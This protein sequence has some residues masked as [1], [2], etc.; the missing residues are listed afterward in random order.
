MKSLRNQKFARQESVGKDQL[1]AAQEAAYRFMHGLT[2]NQ[3]AYEDALRTLYANE[4]AKFCEYTEQW[5][6]MFAI[7]RVF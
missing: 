4:L 6:R 7:A 2:G 5:P 3:T 1:R